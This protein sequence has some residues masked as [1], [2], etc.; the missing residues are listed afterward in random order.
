M[1][2][3]DLDVLKGTGVYTQAPGSNSLAERHCGET[4]TYVDDFDTPPMGNTVF[5]LVTRVAN[6]LEGSLGQ[7]NRGI[8]RPNANPCP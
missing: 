3:G 2:E 5:S 8:E 6:G 4:V 1:Y 7:D